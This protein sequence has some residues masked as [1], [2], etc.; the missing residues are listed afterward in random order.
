RKQF[1]V[2]ESSDSGPG[3]K[4][5][6]GRVALS[7]DGRLLAA[8]SVGPISL[9]D[10]ETGLLLGRL[11]P[12]I[13]P[14]GLGGD[15]RLGSMVFSRDGKAL[16]LADDVSNARIDVWNLDPDAWAAMASNITGGR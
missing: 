3:R 2:P 4:H 10:V 7:P 6:A 16:V 13:Y 9:W 1:L 8:K 15:Y 5:S 14:F 11:G 12:E